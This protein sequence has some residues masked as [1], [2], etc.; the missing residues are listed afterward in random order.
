[1]AQNE[2]GFPWKHVFGFL[3]SI[4]LT[5][6]AVWIT[7]S[8]DLPTNT[9]IT[10]IVVLAFCQAFIQLLLFMHMKEG[11]SGSW[12]ATMI[13]YGIYIAIVIVAGSIWVMSLGHQHHY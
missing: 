13:Y 7:F 9:I 6:L 11:E 5:L 12:Q 4:I 10:L 1:L 8:T 3:L 2:K